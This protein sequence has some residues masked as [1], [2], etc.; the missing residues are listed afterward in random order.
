M[1]SQD[2]CRSRI[3]PVRRR[4]R[5][6]AVP[7]VIPILILLLLLASR[8]GLA[9][10]AEAAWSAL[11]QGGHV[12]LVRHATAPGTGDPAGFRLED[13]A[14]QR[15]LSPAG[16]AQAKAIGANLRWH[17]VRVDRVHSSQW[18]RCL[19]TARLLGLGEVVP[20]PP[21]NSFFASP[22]SGTAQMAEL[23]AWLA[24]QPRQG[25]LVLVTHQ[26]VITALTGV[27]P[28]SGEIVVARPV[29]GGA[30]ELVGR[31]PAPD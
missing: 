22:E 31:I 4:Q 19:E 2:T 28:R 29:A 7:I 18:C 14:T 6:C 23:R 30:F 26:V 9:Q 8:P 20:L 1:S 11:R 10:D 16:R 24:D 3:P 25:A 15:N 12:A 13:C 27:V 17:G 5:L 21:L